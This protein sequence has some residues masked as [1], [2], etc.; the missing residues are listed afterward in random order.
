MNFITSDTTLDKSSVFYLENEKWITPVNQAILVR[1]K[2]LHKCTLTNQIETKKN[3]CIR[4]LN[5]QSGIYKI[6]RKKRVN[7]YFFFGR[8]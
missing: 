5:L 3:L 4:R 2:K 1:K 6:P 8:W 7:G